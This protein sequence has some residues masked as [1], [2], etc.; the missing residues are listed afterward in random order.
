MIGL[1]FGCLDLFAVYRILLFG[2]LIPLLFFFSSLPP[3]YLNSHFY[4]HNQFIYINRR[5]I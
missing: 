3:I 5:L 1:E 4:F 2:I